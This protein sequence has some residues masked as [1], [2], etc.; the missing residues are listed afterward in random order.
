MTRQHDGC[1]L[2]VVP[3]LPRRFAFEKR[4]EAGKTLVE[5]HAVLD[6]IKQAAAGA[7]DRNEP[8]GARRRR[9]READ[10]RRARRAGAVGQHVH[11]DL[12]GGLGGADEPAQCVAVA[13]DVVLLGMVAA[14]ANS[15]NSVRNPSLEKRS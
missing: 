5:R 7:P 3:D 11:P 4:L 1:G 12:G 8:R 2:Q 14:V 6:G 15:I 13:D 10:D 9:D